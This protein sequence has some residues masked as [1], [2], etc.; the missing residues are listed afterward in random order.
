MRN[1]FVSI[2]HNLGKTY[3]W[4]SQDKWAF[5]NWTNEFEVVSKITPWIKSDKFK[6]IF[7]PI[8]LNLTQR[9][10]WINDRA[11]D[12]DICIEFHLDSFPWARWCSTWYM[13]ESKY[14]MNKAIRFQQEYTRITWLAWRWVKWDTTNR[15]WRLWFVRDTKPLSLLVELWF[16]TSKEDLDIILDKWTA[17]II[18]GINNII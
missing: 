7:V 15:H 13:T 10:K 9:I 1:V 6:T 2:W 16:I 11:K 17:W 3:L 14:A 12:W 8:W 4:S 18:A 5:A